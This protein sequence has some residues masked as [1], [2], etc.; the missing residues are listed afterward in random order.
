MAFYAQDK[1]I[2]FLNPRVYGPDPSFVFNGHSY[3]ANDP[4]LIDP[5][6]N[7]KDTFQTVPAGNA[8]NICGINN[9]NEYPGYHTYDDLNIGNVMYYSDKTITTPFIQQVYNY[10]TSK[11]TKINYKN[12]MSKKTTMTELNPIRNYPYGSDYSDI[13]DTLFFRTDL[14]ARQQRKNREIDYIDHY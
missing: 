14:I 6:R 2:T 10:D 8:T 11:A 4:R 12:P 5:I 13:N 9:N 7:I 1:N 3:T